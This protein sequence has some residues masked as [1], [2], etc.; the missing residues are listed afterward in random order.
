MTKRA[1]LLGT[2]WLLSGLGAQ[3]ETRYAVLAGCNNFTGGLSSLYTSLN[4]IQGVRDH[5]LC[6][7]DGY[8]LSANVKMLKDGQAT[9]DRVRDELAAAAQTCQDGDIFCFMYSGHGMA[10]DGAEY[11]CLYDYDYQDELLGQDLAQFSSGVK[12]V[13]ILDTCYS[14]GMFKAAG[15]RS[16]Q[17][18]G[19]AFAER[20]LAAYRVA[21]AANPQGESLVSKAALGSNIAFMTAS[22]KGELSWSYSSGYS[23]YTGYVIEAVSAASTDANGDG[24]LTLKEL[25]D[26]AVPRVVADTVAEEVQTPQSYHPEVLEGIVVQGDPDLIRMDSASVAVSEGDLAATVWL[27]REG[28]GLRAVSVAVSTTGET[29]IPGRDFTAL[30]GKTVSWAAGDLAPKSV[31]I[32][33]TADT[34]KEGAETFWALCSSPKSAVL[35]DT[36]YATLVTIQDNDPGVPGSV[37]FAAPSASASESVGYA[38]L[39]VVRTGGSDGAAQVRYRTVPVTAAAGADFVPAEGVLSWGAGDGSARA[40]RIP[41][42]PDAVWEES[43]RFDVELFDATGA[44][45]A[46]PAAASVTLTNVGTTKAPGKARL[47]PAAQSVCEADGVARVAVAREGGS[48]GAVEVKVAAVGVTAKAGVNYAA[49]NTVLRWAHGDAAPQVYEVALLDDGAHRPDLTFRLQLSDFKGG[50]AGAPNG[51]LATVTLRD[52]KAPVTLAEALDNGA[53]AVASGGTGHWYGQT[54]ESADGADAAQLAS[55]LTTKGRD[56]WLQ[57][58]VTGPGVLAFTWRGG[59]QAEDALQFYVG[60]TVKTQRVGRTGWERVENVVVPAGSQSVK[61]RFVKN[62]AATN[63][64]DSAWVDQVAWQPD[65]ARPAGPQPATGGVLTSDPQVVAWQAASGAASYAV[66]LGATSSVQTQLLGQTE[67]TSLGLPALTLGATIYWRVDAVSAAG[68]VT[69]GAVWLFKVPRGALARVVRPADQA[70][71]VGCPFSQTLALREGSPAATAYSVKGLPQGLSATAGGVISG[72]P[73]KAGTNVVVVA[74]VNGYGTGPTEAFTLTVN[75]LPAPM[76]GAFSGLSGIGSDAEG[77]DRSLAG[78]VQMTVS[79]AGAISGSVRL[80]DGTYSFSGA[81]A[82]EGE[83]VYFEKTFALKSGAATTLRV[84]PYADGALAQQGYRGRLSNAAGACD[85]VLTLNAWSANRPAL[86]EY[87]GYY[88]VALPPGEN[89]T[90]AVMPRGVGYLTVRVE[91]TGSAT[92][93][94]VLSDGTAWS[95]SATVAVAPDGDGLIVPVF[96]VLYKGLGQFWGA[97]RLAPQAAGV[98]DNVAAPYLGAFFSD[99]AASGREGLVW[100]S[101]RQATSRLYPD[102]FE[103]DLAASGG[104]YNTSVTSLEAVIGKQGHLLRLRFDAVPDSS[105]D[106]AV[107]VALSGSTVWLPSKGAMNPCGTTLSVSAQT[108]LFSGSFTLSDTSSGQT[109]TRRATYKGV[110]APLKGSFDGKEYEAPGSGFFT[111]NGLSPTPAT[112]WIDSFGAQLL[113]VPLE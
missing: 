89:E 69:R 19:S 12:I 41:I 111:V 9:Y 112:S 68:R 82:R 58:S 18:Q 52:A 99:V 50:L 110:L 49:T 42:L 7:S 62:S 105:C 98:D 37:R 45:L 103:L 84:W 4:D 93:A 78:A 32:P 10:L 56:V 11:I 44:A 113:W 55:A 102:G 23:F 17:A 106:P 88:T 107:T 29:A 73:S 46:T 61:W 87:V 6:P 39:T 59:A 31:S 43:E 77:G 80:M 64:G 27:V 47:T 16:A 33:I 67:G 25:H 22:D 72:R 51:T 104:A 108:G 20:V 26:Y 2:L 21:K 86:S 74:A 85:V 83:G 71:T 36:Q 65:A 14:G 100:Y 92:L 13:I 63:A 75:A 54:A 95:G 96:A 28:D 79:A 40:V 15:A 8:W 34:L 30:T 38:T 1:C 70:L 53:W 24:S 94:G 91:S 101:A 81:F 97:L 57:A 76:V 5:V 3:A 48:D 66:Y 109:V 35:S 60:S 90:N